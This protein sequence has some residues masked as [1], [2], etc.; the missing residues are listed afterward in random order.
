MHHFSD[1]LGLATDLLLHAETGLVE[2]RDD[3]IVVRTPDAPEY[4][5]GNMLVLHRRPAGIDLKRL[6]HDFAQLI[7][8]PPLITHRTFAWPES[9]DSVGS[10]DAFV[11]QGYNAI[12]CRVLAAHSDDVRPV[13]KN[14]LVKVRPFAVHQDWDDWSRMQLAEMSCPADVTSQRYIAHQQMA[15]RRLIHRGLGN[16]WGAFIND[17]QVGSL[18]LFFLNGVGRFQSVITGKLHR[19]RNVCKSL[20]SEVIK[21]TAAQSDR[22]V[23]VADE[24]YHAGAIYEAMGFQQQGR[25]GSLYQVR[26]DGAA[27]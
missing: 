21:L 7:G 2:S 18:G 19:N 23:V 15:Y 10:L 13:A 8:T 11:E 4:F 9:A 14:S 22:L 17:E 3:Y 12:V 1:N 5:F 24:T 16:W 26:R 25:V 20:M 27:C 6:E